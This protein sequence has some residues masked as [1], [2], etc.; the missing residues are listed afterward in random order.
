MRDLRNATSRRE[1][2]LRRAAIL[3]DEYKFSLEQAY[4]KSEKRTQVAAS[5]PN[6]DHGV[7]GTGPVPTVGA[8]GGDPNRRRSSVLSA[9]AAGGPAANNE[10]VEII[11]Q[12]EGMKSALKRLGDVL[13]PF[14]NDEINDV[15]SFSVCK[16]CPIFL[17]GMLYIFFC[18]RRRCWKSRS[19][20]GPSKS[21]TCTCC[22]RT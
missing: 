17:N 8:A 16:N 9:I 12:N 3:L 5:K 19:R 14:L 11:A 7:S 18:L 20:C 2:V 10:V 13:F 6:G 21:A 1:K 15:S 22:T 4:F